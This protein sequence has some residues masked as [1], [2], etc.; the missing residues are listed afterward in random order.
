MA[1]AGPEDASRRLKPEEI[2]YTHV[3]PGFFGVYTSGPYANGKRVFWGNGLDRI[4]K[5]D[6]DTHQVVSTLMLPNAPKHYEPEQ[7]D[8]SIRYFD[9]N[10]DGLLALYEAF[11]EAQK[12]RSLASIYTLLDHTNTYYISNKK[13]TLRLTLTPTHQTQARP[14]C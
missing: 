4:V 11:K 8:R 6:Q 9:R 13:A 7:A 12:L 2:Q 3:G 1:I 14:S 5:I 10:N